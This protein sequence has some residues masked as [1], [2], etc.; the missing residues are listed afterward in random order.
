MNIN[1]REFLH[2]AMVAAGI[3]TKRVLT[4]PISATVSIVDACNYRCVMCWEHSSE[5]EGWGADALARKY[6]VRKKNK[7][8]VMDYSVYESLVTDLRRSGC[9]RLGIHGIGEPLM[10]KRIVDAVA[11]AKSKG[12]HVSITTN[13]S[14]LTHEMIEGLLDAGLHSLCISINAGATDEYAKVHPTQDN[15][16]FNKIVGNLVY[17]KEYRQRKMLKHPSLSLSNV[18]SSLNYHRTVEMVETCI[19]VGAASVSYRPI[20]IFPETARF[21]LGPKEL[22]RVH[23]DFVRAAVLAREHGI[24]T[25]IDDFNRLIAIRSEAYI[26]A[27]CFIGWMSPMIMANNDVVYCCV[28]RE[29]IGNLADASFE[30]I[31]FNPERKKLNDIALRM[32]KTSQPVPNSRCAGCEQSLNNL[33]VY[34]KLWPLW[35]KAAPDTSKT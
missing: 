1:M 7:A 16:C 27:P 10:H 5:L 25:N 32:H 21:D 8:T 3:V 11:F 6:H 26:P 31:W 28:S 18:V 13:G 9:R 4:G 35:G 17:L 12:M 29:V 23:T 19:K 30:S 33:W 14:L 24:A 22:G 34:R 20:H 15:S 2:L